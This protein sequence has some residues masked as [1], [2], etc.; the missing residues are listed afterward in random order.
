MLLRHT[1]E[2]GGEFLSSG[3]ALFS[4]GSVLQVIK[5]KIMFVM[6]GGL[7]WLPVTENKVSLDSG[8]WWPIG[9]IGYYATV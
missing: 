6:F 1:K 9:L 3:T 2:A 7:L 8:G 4:T 5:K